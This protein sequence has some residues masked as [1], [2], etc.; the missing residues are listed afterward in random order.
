MPRKKP[1]RRTRWPAS[2][3]EEDPQTR[4][5]L[6]YLASLTPTTEF[7]QIR[8]VVGPE[9]TGD[10]LAVADD[11][12]DRLRHEQAM[13]RRG[14]PRPHAAW[15]PLVRQLVARD[16]AASPADI[17]DRLAALADQDD[18]TIHEAL[19]TRR[20]AC[21]DAKLGARCVDGPHLHYWRS[22]GTLDTV[23]AKGIMNYVHEL[24]RPAPAPRSA[25]PRPAP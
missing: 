10:Q 6:A 8:A 21:T 15:K 23:T 1:R 24:R 5:R 19:G 16:P 14:R 4:Q 20:T 12:F 13:F 3:A 18:E 11:V 7:R 25:P 9:P 17:Y 22:K 2:A